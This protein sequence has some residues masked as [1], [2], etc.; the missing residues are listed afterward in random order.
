MSWK[1]PVCENQN[2]DNAV[3]CDIC[4]FEQ[5]LD[6]E[7]YPTLQLS[8]GKEVKP[9]T[10]YKRMYE[11]KNAGGAQACKQCGK[12]SFFYYADTGTLVCGNCG[13][14][15]IITSLP[16]ENE[17]VCEGSVPFNRL[18]R[19]ILEK[20]FKMNRK[21]IISIVAGAGHYVLTTDVGTA[22]AYG[23]DNDGKCKVS[24]WKGIK[25]AVPGLYNTIGLNDKNQIVLA[26]KN[27]DID[28][29]NI[30]SWKDIAAISSG[31]EY[32]IGLLN[33]GMVITAGDHP[34]DID[35]IYKWKNIIAVSAGKE[36]AAG[37]KKDGSVIAAGCNNDGQCEI[38]SW[39][40]I[41]AVS[42]GYHHTIGLKANGTVI[43]A[44][45]EDAYD[46]AVS[47]LNDI[48][49]ISAGGRHSVF[50]TKKGTVIA[51]GRNDEGQCNV[52]KWRDIVAISAYGDRT[53][54]LRADGKVL[55]SGELN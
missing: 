2:D 8:L 16:G 36:H 45:S 54:G 27:Y 48:A 10:F 17:H 41:I 3:L 19:N 5:S 29:I 55:I 20:Y 53:F 35:D 22:E 13:R 12:K 32:L 40:G 31:D 47:D 11:K 38:S 30:K 52:D 49:A 34:F 23:D 43:C 39:A 18:D 24:E 1:C 33:D 4:R 14:E 15:M 25:Y 21:G 7:H 28:P 44:G 50:L 37:L 51:S 9:L 46:K 42:A 6:Y 26:G